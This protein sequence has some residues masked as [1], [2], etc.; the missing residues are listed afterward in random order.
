MFLGDFKLFILPLHRVDPLVSRADVAR[1]LQDGPTGCRGWARGRLIQKFPEHL[2]EVDWD[3]V[4]L[5]TSGDLWGRRLGVSMPHP[6]SR[7]RESFEPLLER[8]HDVA[9]LAELLQ[10][11]DGVAE[12]D[13]ILTIE[14]QIQTH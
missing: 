9:E 2:S 3:G 14:Q 5:R 4:E 1:C 6:S 7:A 8:S 12:S 13:P 11:D 10:D